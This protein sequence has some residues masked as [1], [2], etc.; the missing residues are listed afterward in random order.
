MQDGMGRVPVAFLGR[1]ACW[2][3]AEKHMT[4][5]KTCGTHQFE[6]DEE[7]IVDNEGPLATIAIGGNTED[8]GADGSQHEHE[9]NAPGDVGD[10]FPKR[11]G[12]LRG[13]QGDGEE[14]KGIPSLRHARLA[15]SVSFSVT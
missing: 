15:V 9:R 4:M 14:V 8:D 11:L 6:D 1:P 12:Q 2:D 3:H 7:Q 5:A 10:V 13:C